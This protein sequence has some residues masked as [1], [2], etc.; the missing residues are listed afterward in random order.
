MLSIFFSFDI[1]SLYF[2]TIFVDLEIFDE[3]HVI[4]LRSAIFRMHF[5]QAIV[6]TVV[7]I[8]G[9]I[10]FKEKPPTPVSPTAVMPRI[11]FF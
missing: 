2:P 5:L 4:H 1:L 7:G 3:L 10:F 6:T 8:L 11:K 9:I